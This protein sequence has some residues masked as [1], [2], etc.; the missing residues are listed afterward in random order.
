M[1]DGM[2][3]GVCSRTKT[4]AIYATL[5]E[6]KWEP[7]KD[8]MVGAKDGGMEWAQST[9]K[10]NDDDDD[11]VEG[12]QEILERMEWIQIPGDNGGGSNE[13]RNY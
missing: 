7:K 8:G 1:T 11:A 6:S 10:T 3:E 9:F 13:G 2:M 5:E 4:P 12:R